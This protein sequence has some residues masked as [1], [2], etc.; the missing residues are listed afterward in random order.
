MKAGSR[1]EIR[2]LLE[3]YKALGFERLPLK[4]ESWRKGVMEKESIPYPD[5]PMPRQAGSPSDRLAALQALWAEIGDC[6]R[7]G[8]SS[9]RSCIVFGEGS[10][11]ARIMFIGEAPGKEEDTQGRPFVGEAGQLLDRLIEKMGLR[12]EE[13]YMANIVKCHPPQNRDP[14]E[15]EIASCLLFLRRQIEIISPEA[16]VS[17]GKIASHT[18][19]GAK[20]SLSRFSITKTRGRF[21]EY[22]AESRAIPLMPTFHPA[23]L[24]RSPRDKWL[25][26]ED[27]LA[28][29]KRVGLDSR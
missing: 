27:A 13:V 22:Q 4:T 28:V 10:A 15:D 2:R 26:W 18:L 17:L 8:L 7:C 5:H 14:R 9:G 12:R 11:E 24:L 20:E 6:R 25:T 16:I 1:P 3:L 19:M 23:Y 29:L 21:Y